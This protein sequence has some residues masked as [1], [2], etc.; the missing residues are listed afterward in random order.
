[1]PPSWIAENGWVY[2]CELNSIGYRTF[3]LDGDNV[4][5]ALC[6]DL[7]FSDQDRTENIRSNAETAKLMLE[8]VVIILTTFISPFIA[9][10]ANA[11]ALVNK[12]DLL[13]ST[14]S[15]SYCLRKKRHFGLPTYIYTKYWTPSINVDR[16]S[17]EGHFRI[18]LDRLLQNEKL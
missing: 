1:M 4:R 2:H 6:N 9:N 12:D 7:G 16:G 5:H 15:P 3:V 13:R 17:P 11:K 14:A 18:L 8:A 10:R